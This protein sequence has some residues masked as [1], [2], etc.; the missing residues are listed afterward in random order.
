MRISPRSARTVDFEIKEES[1]EDSN[2][3]KDITNVTK[4]KCSN[5]YIDDS[6]QIDVISDIQK[7]FKPKFGNV[8]SLIL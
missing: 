5:S 1:N 8:P 7:S 2:T 4:D 6:C 3:L